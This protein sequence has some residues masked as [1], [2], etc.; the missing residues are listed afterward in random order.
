MGEASDDRLF[1]I[2]MGEDPKC[3][4]CFHSGECY[5]QGYEEP[6]L[7]E[8]AEIMRWESALDE[9]RGK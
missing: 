7:K 4:D 3:V 5:D 8:Q 1:R 9:A 2:Y 6:C